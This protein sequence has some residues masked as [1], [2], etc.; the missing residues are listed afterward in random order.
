MTPR[1]VD[2]GQQRMDAFGSQLSNIA[3]NM[4]LPS[5]RLVMQG[6]LDGISKSSASIFGNQF[7]P[8]LQL[9]SYIYH[10]LE[11]PLGLDPTIILSFTGLFWAAFRLLRPLYLSMSRFMMDHFMSTIHISSADEIYLHIM[12][13]LAG[14]PH[15]TYRCLTAETMSRPAWEEEKL[16]EVWRAPGSNRTL[17]NFAY[18]KS[19]IVSIV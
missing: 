19:E 1:P 9:T 4:T 13:L 3:A 16:S 15:D 7:N 5:A 14:K 17:I 12:K 11:T 2:T 18:Q 8:S 10:V 6:V